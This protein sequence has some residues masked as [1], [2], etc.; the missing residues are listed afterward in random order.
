MNE[1]NGLNIFLVYFDNEWHFFDAP[2]NRGSGYRGGSPDFG[3]T[4]SNQNILC[5][6]TKIDE[7]FEIGRKSICGRCFEGVK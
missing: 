3:G 5:T 7:I 1:L 4:P 2:D 6:D